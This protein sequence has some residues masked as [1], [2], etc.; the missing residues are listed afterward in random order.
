MKP[1]EVIVYRSPMEK[2]LYDFWTSNTGLEIIFWGFV[3]LV[4]VFALISLYNWWQDRRR[5]R[6]KW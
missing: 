1:Q 5:M 3:S 2:D 4:S 6:R